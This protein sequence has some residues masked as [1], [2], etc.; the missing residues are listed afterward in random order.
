MVVEKGYKQTEVG[1]IPED[2]TI[3]C[4][5]EIG[6]IATG[7]TP[8]TSNKSNYGEDYFFVSPADLGKG[9]YINDTEKKLSLS[10][11]NIA[12]KFP[13]NSVLITCIGS[14]IGKAGIAKQQLTSN[15]QINAVFP[16]D[17]FSIDYL[18]YYLAFV[19]PKIKLSASEQA[20]PM[21]NKTEFGKIKIAI[22]SLPEQTAIANALS[23]MDALIAQTSTLIEKKKAIKQGVMQE[24]LKPKEG[25]VTKNLG[26]LVLEMK[27]GGTPLTSISEYYNGDIPFLSIGDMTSQGKHLNY[28]TSKIS[29]VGLQNSASWVVPKGSLIYSMYASVGFVSINNID[30]AI[31]QAV[32]G[33]RFRD[34]IDLS[35]MYY[36][37]SSMQSSVLKYVGEGTQKNL[38]AATVKQFEIP[39][40]K[41][42]EQRVISIILNN[43]DDEIH[44]LETKLKKLQLQKQ[45]MMQ[46]LLTGKIRLI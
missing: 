25:W 11:F 4:T 44:G 8:P 26:E 17:N 38:N 16:N 33:M 42:E 22:P 6:E 9:K 19:S 40:P 27:S 18:Y 32:L 12:R 10:G 36:T 34:F 41:F 23:D 14:T 35:F 1:V 2:W 7:T 21:I 31:S 46:A 30:V 15:Q 28:T 3:K 20:V 24:L 29:S 13:K 5:A 39:L 45:G 43:I 37:L